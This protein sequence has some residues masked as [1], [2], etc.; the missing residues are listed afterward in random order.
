MPPT[1]SRS[2]RRR[3]LN[4]WPYIRYIW[5]LYGHIWPYLD[6][7][8]HRCARRVGRRAGRRADVARIDEKFTRG[9]SGLIF[10]IDAR[11]GTGGG[12]VGRRVSR[13][14]M[15]N[16]QEEHPVWYRLTILNYPMRLKSA[17]YV[18]YQLAAAIF[19]H[20]LP[21]VPRTPRQN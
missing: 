13:A 15:K 9:A 14:S 21:S 12:Q 20:P 19:L 11:D 1:V 10:F 17:Q 18:L 16:L 6:S 8:F 3:F 5:A 7:I 4:F 2:C